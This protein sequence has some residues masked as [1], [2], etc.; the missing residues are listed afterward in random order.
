MLDLQTMFDQID[1]EICG[2]KE[3][4]HIATR[5]KDK[6]R[7]LSEMYAGMARGEVEHA[8]Q[9]YEAA[10]K[11]QEGTGLTEPMSASVFEWLS[12]KTISRLAEVKYMVNNYR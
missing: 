12:N 11:L 7:T 3:Y 4:S 1:D 9:L 8:T 5:L 10:C 2:A 6:D